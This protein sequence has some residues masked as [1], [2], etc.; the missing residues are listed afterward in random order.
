MVLCGE[1]AWPGLAWPGLA[2]LG[3]RCR[4]QNHSKLVYFTNSQDSANIPRSSTSEKVSGVV[5]SFSR[6]WPYLL[7]VFPFL[8]GGWLSQGL[9][10][11]LGFSGLALPSGFWPFLIGFVFVLEG[12]A[13]PSGGLPRGV[14]LSLSGL[15]LH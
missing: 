11:P 5:P 15:A 3:V 6:G 7:G 9:A 4:N 8:L 1:M 2:W 12:L 10:L 14:G 13:L